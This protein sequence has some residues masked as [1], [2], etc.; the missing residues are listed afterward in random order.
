MKNKAHFNSSRPCSASQNGAALLMVLVV[1]VVISLAAGIAGQSWR[2]LVQRAREAE[3]LWRGE[4]YRQA[5]GSYFQVR[6]GPKNSYP[7]T[8]NDLLEDPR[9]PQTVR[10]LR[11][12]YSDPMTGSEWETIKAPGGGIAGVR[13]P[14][15][16]QPFRQKGFPEGLESFEGKDSYREWEF[17][18]VP[19]KTTARTPGQATAKPKTE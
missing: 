10:H 7:P 2:N 13:S 9:F 18:Y 3:L 14:S 16:L 15:S 17:V 19:A 6:Q 11:R 8:L 1:V 5:I 4:Q 12:L